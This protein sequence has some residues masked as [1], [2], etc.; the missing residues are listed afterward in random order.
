MVCALVYPSGLN[1]L[2]LRQAG[3]RPAPAACQSFAPRFFPPTCATARFVDLVSHSMRVDPDPAV[4]KAARLVSVNGRSFV[5]S[6]ASTLI[7]RGRQ[8]L[9]STAVFQTQTG[10]VRGDNG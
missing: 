6:R 7:K 3:H 4:G 8:L 1:V 10:S 9:M 2:S 5:R